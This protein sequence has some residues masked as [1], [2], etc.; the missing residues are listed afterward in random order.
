L[1]S[2]N[3]CRAAT[4]NPPVAPAARHGF[5]HVCAKDRGAS[6][7]RWVAGRG[8]REDG[9]F[10]DSDGRDLIQPCIDEA[11]ACRDRL[12]PADPEPSAAS[13][14]LRAVRGAIARVALLLRRPVGGGGDR[15]A[16]P[17]A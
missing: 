9:M 15:R 1:P 16:E 11:L 4:R 2:E 10:G 7:D 12:T 8:R 13:R 6:A 5:G 3:P 17:T 14:T